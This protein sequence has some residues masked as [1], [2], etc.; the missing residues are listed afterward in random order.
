MYTLSCCYL[1][2]SWYILF[3]Q[4]SRVFRR[5]HTLEM[6]TPW[7]TI[8]GKTTVERI[9]FWQKMWG[10]GWM[11]LLPLQTWL[12]K[13]N[14]PRQVLGCLKKLVYD[15][16]L[17]RVNASR[18][19][20]KITC[21]VGMMILSLLIIPRAPTTSIFEGQPPKNKAETPMKTGVIWVLGTGLGYSS[22]IKVSTSELGS[23][24]IPNCFFRP[25]A[26]LLAIENPRLAMRN[27]YN[28]PGGKSSPLKGTRLGQMLVWKVR[29]KL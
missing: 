26:W 4:L 13:T 17:Q 7:Q 23:S 14:I 21:E 18:L 3:F 2:N 8:C 9:L 11:F 15:W 20:A 1:F 10:E 16:L 25:T 22:P 28:G 5:G 29:G 24:P 19:Q 27:G 12:H 6:H